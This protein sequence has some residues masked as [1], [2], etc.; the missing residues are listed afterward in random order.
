LGFIK[1]RD[2]EQDQR[3]GPMGAP[4]GYRFLGI[5]ERVGVKDVYLNELDSWVKI[6]P[7]ML[8]RLVKASDSTL[9]AT[10]KV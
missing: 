8:G 9:F 4:D 1:T 7:L 10:P 3:I 2:I 5:G 6:R